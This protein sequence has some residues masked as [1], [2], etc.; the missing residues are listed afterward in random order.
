MGENIIFIDR[1]NTDCDKWDGLRGRFGR[2]DLLP[3]W[4]ADMDFQAPAC[5]TQ[6]L[7]AY[8]HQGVFGYYK[9]PRSYKDAFLDW[10]RQYHDL[11]L[12]RS[13]LRFSPGVVPAINWMIQLLTRPG[14][15]VMVQTPVYY[16]FMD[17]VNSNKRRLICCE[18]VKEG[19]VY[20][21]DYER[22]ARDIEE[23]SVKL[24]ILC[25]PHNPVGRVWTHEELGTMLEICRRH[26]VRVVSDEIHHDIVF[27]PARHTPTLCVEGYE[28]MVI[29]L[30]AP[31]KT[32]NLAGCKNAF[33]VIPNEEIR[34]DYDAFLDALR[35]REGNTFGYIAAEAAYRGGRAWF[36]AVREVIYGNY[37]YIKEQ[38]SRALPGV[39][40]SPLEGTYLLWADFSACLKPEEVSA[41]M[42][43]RCHLA[44]DH[45]D[46][47][48]GPA[49]AGF[50]RM[51]LATDRSLVEQA[52]STIIKN[53]NG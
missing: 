42:E 29:M 38:F 26:G 23:N 1:R 28:D 47:F 39:V 20:R 45:G 35:I 33:V 30:T 37:C 53:L 46:W 9:V 40:L 3:M 25:S 13:W 44:F 7:E 8:V 21:I 50:V 34:R 17:G 4:V 15:A 31:S 14:D 41:F 48:G 24:F 2:D 6:A 27:A 11:A 19:G 22:F 32:F 5:V 52:V 10:E 43:T 12:E 18:L 36:E 16:P 49:F 51:N